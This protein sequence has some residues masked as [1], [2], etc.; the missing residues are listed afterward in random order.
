MLILLI[1]VVIVF[2]SVLLS[3]KEKN[4]PGEYDNTV[5]TEQ[6]ISPEESFPEDESGSE[7]VT[8]YV[9]ELDEDEAYE[10]N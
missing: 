3:G 5:A 9:V 7:Q 10:I 8:D 1:L 4:P 6:T 2:I